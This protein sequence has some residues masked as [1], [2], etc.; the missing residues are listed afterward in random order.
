[1][2]NDRA[3]MQYTYIHSSTMWHLYV[4]N[5]AISLSN[6]FQMDDP[7]RRNSKMAHH[8]IKRKHMLLDQS[9]QP[10][11]VWLEEVSIRL[12]IL[13]SYSQQTRNK[14]SRH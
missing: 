8:F 7:T 2:L 11:G 3:L 10:L 4:K 9:D 12:C 5:N 6:T 13:T 14:V 1:M